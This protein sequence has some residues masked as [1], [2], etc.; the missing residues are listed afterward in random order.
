MT[1]CA[2]RIRFLLILCFLFADT[3]KRASVNFM[4]PMEI[5]MAIHLSFGQRCFALLGIPASLLVAVSLW[6]MWDRWQTA[7][8][9]AN[10]DSLAQT[11]PVVSG[12]IHE[13]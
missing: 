9:L 4:P 8:D 5:C 1:V 3:S 7:D 13:M 2:D 12:L 10:L 6:L 11:A